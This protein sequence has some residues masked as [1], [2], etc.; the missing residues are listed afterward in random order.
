[1][2]GGLAL[3]VVLANLARGANADFTSYLFGSIATTS[4]TDRTDAGGVCLTA[5]AFVYARYRCIAPYCVDEDSGPYCW[6]AA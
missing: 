3:A 4:T 1:M 6:V 5:W 2:S